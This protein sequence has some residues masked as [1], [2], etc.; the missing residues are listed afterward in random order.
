MH[1]DHASFEGTLPG[2]TARA[3]IGW[4]PGSSPKK[5][6]FEEIDL[7]LDTVVFRMDALELSLVWR[8]T[9][10]VDDEDKPGIAAVHLLVEDGSSPSLDLAQAQTRILASR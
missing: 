8:G 1:P 3:F 2:I 4:E 10:P 5:R 9:I 7:H 6:P